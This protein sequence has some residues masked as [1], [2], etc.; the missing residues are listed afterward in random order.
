ME[1]NSKYKE[2][3]NAYFQGLNYEHCPYDEGSTDYI[4]WK[5]GY[6][7]AKVGDIRE[8]CYPWEP[9]SP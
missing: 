2:G 3:F 9:D 7:E 6:Y 4:S 5:D 8:F 1:G